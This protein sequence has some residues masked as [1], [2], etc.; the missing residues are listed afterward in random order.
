MCTRTQVC[1]SQKRAL[2][3][4]GLELHVVVSCLTW[5]PGIELSSLKNSVSC[6]H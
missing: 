5:V 2:D 4:L 1:R 6:N 3:S